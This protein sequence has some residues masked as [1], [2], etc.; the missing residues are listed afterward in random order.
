[1]SIGCCWPLC[2]VRSGLSGCVGESTILV[3]LRINFLVMK[4]NFRGYPPLCRPESLGDFKLHQSCKSITICGK[5]LHEN[6]P[7]TWVGLSLFRDD[8]AAEPPHLHKNIWGKRGYYEIFVS[9]GAQPLCL[10]KYPSFF[11]MKLSFLVAIDFFNTGAIP[12]EGPKYPSP[13][14]PQ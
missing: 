9:C 10:F 2:S 6:E 3:R 1:V 5:M 12:P 14:N 8:S 13:L 7:A 4:L 11:S